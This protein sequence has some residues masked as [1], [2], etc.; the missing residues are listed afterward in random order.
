MGVT[1]TFAKANRYLTAELGYHLDPERADNFRGLLRRCGYRRFEDAVAVTQ[2]R[3]L[4]VADATRR[5]RIL[6]NAI[7]ELM[8]PKR[9]KYRSSGMRATQELNSA[10]DKRIMDLVALD[11]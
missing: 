10:L 4:G 3:A 11:D 2:L 5:H 7:W 9:G 8:P 6:V 1:D